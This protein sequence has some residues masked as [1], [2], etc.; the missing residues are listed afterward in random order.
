MAVVVVAVATI[1]STYIQPSLA[2]LFHH[3]AQGEPNHMSPLK[4]GVHC[5]WCYRWSVT[6][7]S[8]ESWKQDLIACS[9]IFRFCR[10]RHNRFHNMLRRPQEEAATTCLKRE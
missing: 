4:K 7:F 2:T 6:L 10:P 1:A 8:L 3:S 9:L 5:P